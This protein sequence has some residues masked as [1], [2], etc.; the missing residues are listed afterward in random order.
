MIMK[1]PVPVAAAFAFAALLSAA[2]TGCGSKN[3][4]HNYIENGDFSGQLN[5]WSP[6]YETTANPYAYEATVGHT[7]PGSVKRVADGMNAA[8]TSDPIPVTAG[9]SLRIS[10]WLRSDRA[11]FG[12]GAAI[13]NVT[14]THDDN[15][16][17]YPNIAWYKTDGTHDWQEM[18]GNYAVPPGVKEIRAQLSVWGALSGTFWFDDVTVTDVDQH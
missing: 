7:S 11:V 6:Y 10:A 16:Q 1:I 15:S 14:A 18:A 5:H 17:T 3:N 2:I 12:S 4:L 8:L 13:F 9:Q